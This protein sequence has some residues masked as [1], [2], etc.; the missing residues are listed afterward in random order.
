M[1][2]KVEEKVTK[3]K[4]AKVEPKAVKAPKKSVTEVPV[5]AP[6][7]EIPIATPAVRYFDMGDS[8]AR[9]NLDGTCAKLTRQGGVQVTEAL[10]GVEGLTEITKQEAYVKAF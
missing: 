8:V 10:D 6:V 5:T 7:V 9:L 2:K 3:A 1:A 4:L